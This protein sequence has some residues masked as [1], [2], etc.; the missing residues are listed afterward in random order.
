M[1]TSGNGYYVVNNKIYTDKIQAILDA[2]KTSA[3]LTWHFFQDIFSKVQWNIEPELSLPEFYRI[4]AQQIRDKYDYV[5]VRV[6]GGA[7][8]TNAIWS[9]LNN[10][11]HVDEIITDVPTSGLNQFKWNNKDTSVGNTLSEIKYVTYPLLDEIRSKSPNTKI[12]INDIF[13]DVLNITPE[14]WVGNWSEFINP[15][16]RGAGLQKFSH[17][18]KLAEQGKK[19][20]IV[21]GVDKPQ[22]RYNLDRTVTVSIVDRIVNLGSKNPFDKPYPNVDRVLFYYTP[23]LPEM[24]VKQCHVICKHIHKKENMWISSILRA[25]SRPAGPNALSTSVVNND[26]GIPIGPN[27]IKGAY[28]QA[29]A[30]IIY[31][32]TWSSGIFQCDKVEGAFMGA[33]NNW[34]FTA[35]KDTHIYQMMISEFNSFYKKINP[36]YLDN[37]KNAFIR[38]SQKYVIG[39]VDNWLNK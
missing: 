16:D 39:S 3:D 34:F 6:S 38:F 36:K 12:T 11:I 8:S 13:Q 28:Q 35:H 18:V 30:P 27:Y 23:D 32:G 26:L 25:I 22:L 14:D 1:N 24:M 33:H 15:V 2:Q 19:I 29:I 37:T 5:I 7:D 21:W 20:G 10:G 31:P 9:F 4:R 17:L